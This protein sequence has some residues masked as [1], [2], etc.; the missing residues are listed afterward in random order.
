MTKQII[1]YKNDFLYTTIDLIHQKELLNDNGI[2]IVETMFEIDAN[3]Y[4]ILDIKSL[5]NKAKFYFLQ[6]KSL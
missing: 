1:P 6:K 2:L 4:K 5:K 3:K